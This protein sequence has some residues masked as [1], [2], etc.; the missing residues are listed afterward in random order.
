MAVRTGGK[1]AV[2][3]VQDWPAGAG[4]PGRGVAGLARRLRADCCAKALGARLVS[5]VGGVAA[6]VQVVSS[7]AAATALALQL[8]SANSKSFAVGVLFLL[9]GRG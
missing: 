8:P 1:G 3:W 4:L 9:G 7:A 5:M 2:L 6:G